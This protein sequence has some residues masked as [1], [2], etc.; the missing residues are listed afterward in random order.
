[1]FCTKWSYFP[2]VNLICNKSWIAYIN[3][4]INF[5]NALQ[6]PGKDGENLWFCYYSWSKVFRRNCRKSIPKHFWNS[7]ILFIFLRRCFSN[8]FV[9]P[10]DWWVL[11]SFPGTAF[12]DHWYVGGLQIFYQIACHRKNLHV[13]VCK[14]TQNS[15]RV[16][17]LLRAIIPRYFILSFWSLQH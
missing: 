8:Y 9:W 16:I 13:S 17:R 6:I 7:I 5:C 10:H 14:H 15:H 4:I 12:L 11:S 3:T 2:K 1:M